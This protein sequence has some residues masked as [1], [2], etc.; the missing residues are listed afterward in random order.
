MSPWLCGCNPDEIYVQP[1]SHGEGRFTACQE[2]LQSLKANSQI[3]FQ[4]TDYNDSAWAIEGV[5]S[6]DGRV[7]G[8]T[9][10]FE[11]Y[12]E[13]TAKNIPGNKFLPLF[14]GGVKYFK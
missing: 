12:G 13:F 3:A 8:K 11:R 7:L 9:A 1:I 6:A 2:A 14:E 5:S 10:H 4:Y